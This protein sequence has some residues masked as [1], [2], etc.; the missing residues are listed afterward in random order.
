MTRPAARTLYLIKRAETASRTG[1]EAFLHD[2]GVT[3]GQYTAL[4]LLAAQRN[5]SSADMARKAG[6]TPQSM[7]ETI[8]GLERK[9]LIIRAENPEHRRILNITLTEAGQALL[10]RCDE[11]TDA[12]EA[13][14]LQGLSPAQLAALR[15]ALQVIIQNQG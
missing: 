13:R 14:L 15:E 2:L 10:T 8:S 5:Q 9:G 4:S 12:L 7:S 6:V 1:L 11:Q 3:P